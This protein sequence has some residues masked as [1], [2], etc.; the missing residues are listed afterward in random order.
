MLLVADAEVRRPNDLPEQAMRVIGDGATIRAALTR[1]SPMT[2][3][4]PETLNGDVFFGSLTT[5]AGWYAFFIS[6]GPSKTFSVHPSHRSISRF[7]TGIPQMILRKLTGYRK[8]E[9][10]NYHRSKD[11]SFPELQ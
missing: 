3:W 2:A 8:T 7:I 6:T 9:S 1:L 11:S 4:Q 5:D 10:D